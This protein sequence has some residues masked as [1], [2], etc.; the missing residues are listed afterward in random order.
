MMRNTGADGRNLAVLT[1]VAVL[2]A[3]LRFFRLG[4]QSF[5]LDEILTIGSYSSPEGGISYGVKL[6][7]DVHGPLYSLA[8]HFWSMASSSEAWLRAPGAL[9]GVVTVILMYFW[10]RRESNES[11][12]LAGALLMAVNPFNIYYSQDHIISG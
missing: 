5:W 3:V 8:M 7:W 9:A 11:T 12:A 2:A 10:L 6:L 4:H 1:A